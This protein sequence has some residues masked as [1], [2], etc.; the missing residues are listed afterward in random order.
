MKPS[1]CKFYQSLIRYLTAELR[2]KK[3]SALKPLDFERHF[4]DLREHGGKNGKGLS[5]KTLKS[6]RIMLISC[7]ERALDNDIIGANVVKKTIVP[8]LDQREKSYMTNED[9]LRL[10]S[11]ADSG[12]YYEDLQKVKQDILKI[13]NK[14]N[15]TTKDINKGKRDQGILYL[16]KQWSVVIHLVLETGIR[17]GEI[18]GMT[19]DCVDFLNNTISIIHNLQFG[20]LEQPK[21]NNSIRTIC[22][23]VDTMQILNTWKE[24]QSR[25]A[26]EVGDLYNNE[27]DL[28]FCN[29]FGRPVDYDN[30]RCRYFAKMVVKAGLP[31]TITFHSCRHSHATALLANGTDPKTISKRLGHADVDVGFTLKTYT[32]VLSKMDREAA[33]MMGRILTRGKKE[34]SE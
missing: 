15:K 14:T 27:M 9:M 12:E 5:G 26:E 3:L 34:D 6:Y 25:Y 19:W 10:M 28:V 31:K 33:D 8:K 21:T 32:H 30:F 20:K 18:F 2:K 24:Y 4:N 7:M 22:V 23:D 17:R 16:I 13:Q 29:S 11:V 1:T